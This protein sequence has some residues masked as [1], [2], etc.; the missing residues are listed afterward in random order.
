MQKVCAFHKLGTGR[1]NV[2]FSPCFKE[3][4]FGNAIKE[5]FVGFSLLSLLLYIPFEIAFVKLITGHGDDH[6][7]PVHHLIEEKA[8]FLV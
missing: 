6:K 5:R 2:K 8:F 4:K 1:W 7:N 3:D